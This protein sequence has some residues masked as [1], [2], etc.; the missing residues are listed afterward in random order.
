VHAGD[1]LH[2]H[3]GADSGVQLVPE[4]RGGHRHESFAKIIPVEKIAE[5]R[6]EIAGVSLSSPFSVLLRCS[7]SG[8]VDKLIRSD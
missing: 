5:R 1:F 4:S 2:T 8:R 6:Q 3:E 7:N